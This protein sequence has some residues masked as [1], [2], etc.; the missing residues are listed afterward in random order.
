MAEMVFNC[1]HCGAA[2]QCDSQYA[3]QTVACPHCQGGI[4]VPAAPAPEAPAV[5]PAQPPVEAPVEA[6]AEQPTQPAMEA[7]AEMPVEAPAEAPAEQEPAGEP[8]P[9][10][11]GEVLIKFPCPGCGTELE[12]PES[13]IGEPVA[14]PDCLTEVTHSIPMPKPASGKKKIIMKRKGA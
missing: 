6:P 2:V 5:E 9:A 8:V 7:P 10:L 3:G 4:I 11:E 13:A 12:I 1:P 14:C